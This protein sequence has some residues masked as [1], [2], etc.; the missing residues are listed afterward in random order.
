MTYNQFLT[1]S[2]N[3]E[4]MWTMGVRIHTLIIVN[5]NLLY[6]EFTF[7]FIFFRYLTLHISYI[8]SLLIWL[9]CICAT[10]PT[11]LAWNGNATN[12]IKRYEY[13]Y[14]VRTRQQGL[15][16]TT[17]SSIDLE[18]KLLAATTESQNTKTIAH[19]S[20]LYAPIVY[21]IENSENC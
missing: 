13:Y 3:I 17:L 18:F 15:L 10:Q 8:M 21:A 9:T 16:F 12:A 4:F 20:L 19:L 7:F 1:I 6:L 11:L 5:G 2:S 14:C